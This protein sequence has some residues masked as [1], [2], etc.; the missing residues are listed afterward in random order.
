[1]TYA[2]DIELVA[3]VCGQLIAAIDAATQH[4][5]QDWMYHRLSV[6]RAEASGLTRE[7]QNHKEDERN[8]P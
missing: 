5:L 2:Y 4:D 3:V 8:E 7:M 6:L 1:M